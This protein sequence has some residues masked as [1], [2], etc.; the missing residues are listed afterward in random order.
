MNTVTKNLRSFFLPLILLLV[1][2][3]WAQN[4]IES[5]GVSLQGSDVVLKLTTSKQL[6]AEPASFSVTNPPR[7]A[8]DFPG[9]TN[10]LGRNA[11]TI[12]EGDLRS[13]NL[14]QVG[15]RSRLVLNLKQIRQAATRKAA[16]ALHQKPHED[17][18]PTHQNKR[19]LEHQI[20]SSSVVGQCSRPTVSL[21][22]FSRSLV[23]RT[24]GFSCE[25]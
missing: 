14:V 25:D 3:A 6:A 7:I 15:D 20:E 22:E 2:P 12:N 10:A 18:K 4:A 13:I 9:V 17:L 19:T 8:F 16:R 11:Q 1:Q 21:L 23:G 5:L 24:G